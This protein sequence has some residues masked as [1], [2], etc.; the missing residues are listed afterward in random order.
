MEEESLAAS[1]ILQDLETSGSALAGCFRS[2]LQEAGIRA[3]RDLQEQQQQKRKHEP[4]VKLPDTELL[5]QVTLEVR[6]LSSQLL[7]GSVT[8]LWTMI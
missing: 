7:E 8:A 1:C 5:L 4:Q 2:F 6:H 3:S